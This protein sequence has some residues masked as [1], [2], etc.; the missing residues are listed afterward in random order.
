MIP[1]TKFLLVKLHCSGQIIPLPESALVL[2]HKGFGNRHC[3]KLPFP[4]GNPQSQFSQ[5][6]SE[7]LEHDLH[8]HGIGK[9]EVGTVGQLLKLEVMGRL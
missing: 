7:K 6:E 8:G 2:I 3:G 5:V 1:N 9:M 4:M